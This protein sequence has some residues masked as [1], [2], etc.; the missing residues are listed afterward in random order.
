MG[1]KKL[2]IA[3]DIG[4]PG[5]C[6]DEYLGLAYF[7]TSQAR[8]APE[9]HQQAG[10]G[11]AVCHCWQKALTSRDYLGFAWMSRKQQNSFFDRLG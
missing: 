1:L 9:V 8:D 5:T 11:K 7:Y 3:F 6:T 10:L 2:G 4:P